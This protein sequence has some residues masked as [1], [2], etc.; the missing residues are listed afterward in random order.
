MCLPSTET[1]RH[2]TESS[3][4]SKCLSITLG[5]LTPS[6]I[7]TSP[8]FFLSPLMSKMRRTPAFPGRPPA[9]TSSCFTEC[10]MLGRFIAGVFAGRDPFALLPA[11]HQFFKCRHVALARALFGVVASEAVFLEDRTNI[12]DD[13]DRFVLGICNRH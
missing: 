13:A 11:G 9:M 7:C 10:G 2:N 12:L 8:S 6:R 5:S 4:S 3:V 1:A